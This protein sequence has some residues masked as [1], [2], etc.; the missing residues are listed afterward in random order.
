MTIIK[1]KDDL[2]VPDNCI[3]CPFIEYIDE[4][5][6]GELTGWSTAYCRCLH[7]SESIIG[8]TRDPDYGHGRLKNCPIISFESGVQ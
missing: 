4:V 5:D 3:D 8:D 7:N 2:V 6:Y 1:L